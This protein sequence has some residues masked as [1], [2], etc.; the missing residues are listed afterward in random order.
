VAADLLQMLAAVVFPV[1]LISGH[2]VTNKY[3]DET[4]HSTTAS[5]TA[6]DTSAI[7][8]AAT[9]TTNSF[10]VTCLVSTVTQI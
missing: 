3:L 5:N 7:T 10:S 9:S 2:S 1:C 6:I 4:F 8:S